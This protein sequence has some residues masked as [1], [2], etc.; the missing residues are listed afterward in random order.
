MSTVDIAIILAYLIFYFCCIGM[1]TSFH[2]IRRNMFFEQIYKGS[3]L[4]AMIGCY[5][6][7][8]FYYD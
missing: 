8:S 3:L 5:V 2:A 7:W 1:I 6:M 4:F